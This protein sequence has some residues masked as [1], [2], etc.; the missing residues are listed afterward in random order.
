MYEYPLSNIF[1]SIQP[2]FLALA[3]GTYAVGQKMV[4]FPFFLRHG[5]QHLVEPGQHFGISHPV[6]R[7]LAS[8]L[9][10]EHAGAMQQP[11]LL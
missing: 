4:N 8:F 3:L 2:H 7:V 5:P 11:H 6:K 9:A 10:P 1:L